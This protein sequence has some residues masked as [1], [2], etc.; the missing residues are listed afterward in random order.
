MD[1]ESAECD[2]ISKGSL[3]FALC[4]PEELP[5]LP[6]ISLLLPRL[7]CNSVIS[8]HCNLCLTGSSESPA[9]ASQ[10][11]GITEMGL[12]HVAQAGL[13]FLSSSDPSTSASLSAGITGGLEVDSE[14]MHAWYRQSSHK[15]TKKAA[16]EA[17]TTGTHH[18]T[19]LIFVF[20]VEMGFHH[21]GQ[22]GLDLLTFLT[23]SSKLECNGAISAHCNLSFLGSNDSLA[24]PSQVVGITSVCHHT[25][26]IFVFLV[27][28]GFHHVGQA[29]PELLTLGDP[30][31]L[32]SQS[33]GITGLSH[34]SRSVAQAGVQWC[35]HSSL[36]PH[37]PGLKPL[38]CLSLATSWDYRHAPPHRANFQIFCRDGVSILV[39]S[40]RLESRGA[41]WAHCN[42]RLLG[43]SNFPAS[44]SQVAGTIGTHCHG[45]LVFYILVET[46]CCPGWSR[47][48]ELRQSACCSLPKYWNYRHEPLQLARWNFALVP[49]LECNGMIS[50][51][52][53]LRFLGS[54]DS[55]ASG[56]QVAGVTGMRHHTWL[57]FV[58][59]VE[60]GLHHVGQAGLELLTSNDVPTLAFQSATITGIKMN[61]M[62]ETP[63]LPAVF[64][65]VKLAAV[66][67]V[68]YVIVR[69]LNLKS[70]TAPPDLYFQDSGLSRFLLKSCPLL[71]KESHSV[72]QAREQWHDLGLL[73]LLTPGVKRLWCL[74]LLSSWIYRCASPHL[75]NFCIFSRDRFRHVSQAGLELLNSSDPSTSPSP[76]VGITSM[77]HCTWLQ[78]CILEA[79]GAGSASDRGNHSLGSTTSHKTKDVCLTLLPKLE[80]SGT[81]MAHCSLDLLGSRDPPI[82]DSQVSG[83]K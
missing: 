27:E 19:Q 39:L 3:L 35:N 7:Q 18:H 61:A 77:S 56:S 83:P 59:L 41:I 26:L 73:Q 2:R 28:M 38:S 16:V 64:D 12:H 11:A 6:K 4:S 43:S 30:P 9:S 10:V 33:S 17:G 8:A 21:V 68:L 31:K 50:A 13:K 37:L 63:E 23:L 81:I 76:S 62:L 69:C 47:T 78:I 80:C 36:K 72:T 44:A 15:K 20:L 71:T 52:Y 40:P 55:L 1:L 32:A 25:W 34:G 79:A 42:L 45:W 24:S 14:Q 67:A 53:K 60:S 51:S 58:F 46:A 75:S 66:A 5:S 65:G 29:G 57:L 49:R 82:S 22:D 54:S 74:S 70:P 48:P